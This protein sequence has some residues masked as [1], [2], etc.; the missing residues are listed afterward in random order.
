MASSSVTPRTLDLPIRRAR[1]ELVPETRGFRSVDGWLLV[2]IAAICAFGLVMVYSAS[3]VLAYQTTGN[4]SYFFERQLVFLGVGATALLVLA[5]VDY[6]RL[7]RWARPLALLCVIL[8]VLVLVPHIGEESNGSRRWFAA[9]PFSLQP[10]AL[11][12]VVAIVVLARWLSERNALV[13]S[14]RGV[15]DYSIVLAI[16]I[17]LI[18]LEKDLGSAIIVAA[19]GL[20][21]LFLGGARKLHLAVMV[22]LGGAVCWGAILMEPYRLSRLTCIGQ[23]LT[24]DP[25]NACWQGVQ[26]LY[27]L[28]SGGISGVGLGNSIQKYS[29]LPEAHTDFIF[30]IIGEELGLI[31]TVA[32]LL[33]FTFLAWRGIR[34]ALRAPD[35]FGFL[36]AGGITAWICI[37]AFINIAAV[38]VLI[39]TTGIPLPFISYGGS[40]LVVNL[41]AVGILCNVSAQGRR[42][43]TM[44]R[45]N[46]DRRGR[47]RGTPDAGSGGR[48]RVARL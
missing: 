25:L 6:H 45:A 46:V 44:R 31:G 48:R 16:P 35:S 42:Q 37:Q 41:M 36:L 39:P 38:T 40:S 30:A 18:L 22:G 10:S 14:W 11:A 33:A 12:M 23:P 32:V 8:L 2:V 13:R 5:R 3:E 17:G 34:A 7:L 29:W 27:G 20:L 9:G 15:R 47:D 21:L 19:V 1:V 4:P 24:N 43:G 28:G 26:A